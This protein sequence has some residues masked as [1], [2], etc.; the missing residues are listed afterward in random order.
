MSIKPI[1]K[2][3]IANRG[4]IACRILQTCKKMGIATVAVYSD[5]EQNAPFV[6]L[7]DEAIHIGPPSAADSYL[8]GDKIIE[9]AKRVGVD[10]IHPGY[11]FLSENAEF[12]REVINSGIIF[13][14]PTSES[15]LAIG[16]KIEAK[17][18]LAKHLPSV[19]LIPGYNG[20][21]QNMDVFISESRK[22]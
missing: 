12:A 19:H 16:D 5:I 4:E 3:L 6:K 9:A 15:I 20:D 1:K 11:G 21:S 13:I 2:L 10:A 18:L 14:G 17:N 8:R 7:A 22:I